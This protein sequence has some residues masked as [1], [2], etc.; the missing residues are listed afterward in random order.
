VSRL[1]TPHV[2]RQPQETVLYALVKEHLS[3]FLQHARESYAGPLPKY[4]VDEFRSY[5]GERRGELA[6]HRHLA[7]LAALRD[8]LV[9][10]GHLAT[11]PDGTLDVDDASLDV[12][13]GPLQ[14]HDL[15]TS[16]PGA[17]AVESSW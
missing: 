11:S 1:S 17:S 13:V 6:R 3:A 15:A 2:P 14:R 10:L 16:K 9:Y 4:V 5:L 8:G 7:T 12:E